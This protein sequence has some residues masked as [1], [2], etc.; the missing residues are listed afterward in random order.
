MQQRNSPFGKI[1]A[2]RRIASRDAATNILQYLL[3]LLGPPAE[4]QFPDKHDDSSVVTVS[5]SLSEFRCVCIRARVSTDAMPD[6][7]Y[8]AGLT[9]ATDKRLNVNW[10]IIH[11]G[12]QLRTRKLLRRRHIVHMRVSCTHKNV[13]G[14]KIFSKVNK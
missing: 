7:N 5:V 11:N 8:S 4:E 14:T 9:T 6:T 2:V 12:G 3:L 10:Y 1:F 13:Y